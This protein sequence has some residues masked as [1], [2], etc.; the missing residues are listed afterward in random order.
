MS[1][2]KP[3][4]FGAAVAPLEGYGAHE[5]VCFERALV[6]RDLFTGGTRTFH[7]VPDAQDFRAA[8]YQQYGEAGAPDCKP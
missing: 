1:H 3:L 4:R 6:V 5:W 8:L 2:L 7:T